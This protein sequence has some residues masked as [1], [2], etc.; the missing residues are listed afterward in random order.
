MSGYLYKDEINLG[1]FTVTD[2]S[3]VGIDYE[4]HRLADALF[5]MITLIII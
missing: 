2:Q 1:S 4:D 5:V 3:F